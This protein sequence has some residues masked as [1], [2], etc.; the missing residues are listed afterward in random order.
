MKKIIKETLKVSIGQYSDAG[1][2]KLN[3]DFHGMY[4]PSEPLLASKGITAVIADGISS[5]DV[6]QIASETAVSGFLSD[7]YSTSDA[8]S[9]KKSGQQVLRATNSWLYSQT[10]NG[11]NRFNKD[12]GYICTF[13]ALILKSR[14]AHI[15][16]CGDS[17]ISRLTHNSL[18]PLTTDH[19]YVVSDETSY[20]TRALGIHEYLETDY[21]SFPLE[22]GDVFMLSTDGVHEFISDKDLI[23][24]VKSG[25]DNLDLLAQRLSQQAL[26]AGSDDNLT[27]QIVRV[28]QL[29]EPM[30][31]EVHQQLTSLPL[32]PA[33]RP[34]SEFDGYHILREIYISSRSHVYL[35]EDLE[36]KEKV[37]IKTPSAELK[38]NEQ[39]LESFLMEDWIAKRI[40]NPH[41]LK[42]I[43]AKRKRNYLYIVT[44]FIEGQNLSQWMID[45]PQPTIEKIRSIAEQIAKGIQA[46]H[47][48]EMIHQDIRPNNIMI[49]SSG[50]VKIIDFGSTKVA[51]IT[52]IVSNN[53]GIVGTMQ[54][55][56]PE[57]FLHEYITFKA[58]IY[59]I[60]VIV[61]EM[62]SGELPYGIKVCHATTKAA[63]RKLYY[64]SLTIEKSHVPEWVD[65]AVK[66]AVNIAPQKRYDEISEFIHDLRQPNRDFVNKT[67]PP[68]MERNPVA[69]WQSISVVLVLVIVY[70]L[71]Q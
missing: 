58:D 31:D 5:S 55:S 70:L 23:E 14:T 56:A 61:Y 66:K 22:E 67:R 17:R 12:K 10:R 48:Q 26:D 3:Q 15:F 30:V 52:D 47:R 62:L 40:D 45:N 1:Q 41:V 63:Q 20:L 29:P 16:H 19:R 38:D 11:P 50:T 64:H 9:V 27:L 65:D 32:P 39:Y 4:I 28:D 71:N 8:W 33:L 54:Y 25:G 36:T 49:D 21:V 60:G 34:R 24:C 7:Y 42:A 2:K 68:L 59:S 43:P 69:V 35:A 57:Y 53:E 44:E 6:S 18:E 51:G 13:S 46:F 37:V